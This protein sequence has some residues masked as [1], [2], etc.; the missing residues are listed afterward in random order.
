MSLPVGAEAVEEVFKALVDQC[1]LFIYAGQ[2]NRCFHDFIINIECRFHM[3][4]YGM[5]IWIRHG[6]RAVADHWEAVYLQ[7]ISKVP[8]PG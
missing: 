1:R 8:M 3:Y 6:G 2:T 5:Y 4:T 7:P